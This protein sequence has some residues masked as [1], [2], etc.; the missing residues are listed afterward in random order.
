MKTLIL[1]LFSIF[2]FLLSAPADV[3]IYDEPQAGPPW[4]F[5]VGQKRPITLASSILET[6]SYNN[7][8]SGVASIEGT[9]T[10]NGNKFSIWLGDD[11]IDPTEFTA[12]VYH[13]YQKNVAA[14]TMNVHC[15]GNTTSDAQAGNM[16]SVGVSGSY[17]MVGT[18]VGV[19]QTVTIP[20]SAFAFPE[21]TI[22]NRFTFD[23]VH[24]NSGWYIDDIVLV[25]DGVVH[26]P[27]PYP[28][29]DN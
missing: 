25:G 11:W 27:N 18:R 3:V 17:G 10:A 20:M 19:W 24:A 29:N 5:M 8:Y 7:A 21:G 14:G 13:V 12:L 22:V 1:A 15:Y 26:F 6:C 28:P 16:A 23:V 4:Y 9:G 2:S